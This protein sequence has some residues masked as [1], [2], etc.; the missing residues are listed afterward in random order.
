MGGFHQQR[1]PG[2]D[3]WGHHHDG[4]GRRRHG[5]ERGVGRLDHD[6]GFVDERILLDGLD[7]R[8]Q[9][10]GVLHQLAR[11]R[12]STLADQL[13]ERRELRGEQ[14]GHERQQRRLLRRR[15]LRHR[16]RVRRI[17]SS[18]V[19]GARG[20]VRSGRRAARL[21]APHEPRVRGRLRARRLHR[22]RARRA[23]A[24]L[25]TGLT[26]QPIRRATLYNSA[27]LRRPPRAPSG[28]VAST[29]S[30]LK[31]AAQC[32]GPGG[33]AGLH[34]RVVRGGG[35]GE[36]RAVDGDSRRPARP[37]GPPTSAPARPRAPRRRAAPA[38]SARRRRR[39]RSRCAS[40]S[41]ETRPVPPERTPRNPSWTP[42]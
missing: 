15:D 2:G 39:A 36:L 40:T 35:R 12:A 37:P 33:H 19:D 6:H 38:R 9:H 28:T 27:S 18:R 34:Q 1:Q 10:V 4:D 14:R 23:A 29:C 16:R 42:A 25:P 11:P 22:P 21:P 20:G 7:E 13:D 8:E 24:A 32:S 26:C 5:L 30:Q 31:T 41:R 3:G 17:R